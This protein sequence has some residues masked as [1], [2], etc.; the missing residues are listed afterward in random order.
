MEKRRAPQYISFN[1]MPV[2]QLTPDFRRQFVHGQDAMLARIEVLKGCKVHE[3]Q[4]VNEQITLILKGAML[5]RLGGEERI[6]RPGEVVIIPA[7]L[8]HSGE[9]LEDTMG[10]DIFSPPRADWI[11]GE[12]AYLRQ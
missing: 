10:F 9:A 8:P 3:H 11:N 5:L 6:V 12:D 2:E 1:T 4:H 7:N